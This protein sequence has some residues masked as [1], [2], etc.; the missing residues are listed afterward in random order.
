MLR[1]FVEVGRFC[2]RYFFRQRDANNIFFFTSLQNTYFNCNFFFRF[3][4]VYPLRSN[5]NDHF[6]ES[7]NF[8][9]NNALKVFCYNEQWRDIMTR[10][11]VLTILKSCYLCVAF[12][13]RWFFVGRS[14]C[15]CS[16]PFRGHSCGVQVII[17]IFIAPGKCKSCFGHFLVVIK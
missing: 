9:G 6:V 15:G 5:R 16:L 1:A 14:F 17:F 13:E 12:F 2:S 4:L 11:L 7:A 3:N 8:Q 10:D